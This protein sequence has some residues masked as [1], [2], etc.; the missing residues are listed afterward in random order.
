MADHNGYETQTQHDDLRKTM[1]EFFR[2]SFEYKVAVIIE[3]LNK[4]SEQSKLE[5]LI[6][7][8]LF[9]LWPEKGVRVAA[10]VKND[11]V[12]ESKLRYSEVSTLL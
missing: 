12:V 2:A 10:G 8:L 1:P 4:K 9:K 6:F 3:N 7:F 11:F 5:V